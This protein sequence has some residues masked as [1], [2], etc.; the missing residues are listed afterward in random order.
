MFGLNQSLGW[1]SNPV[2]VMAQPPLIYPPFV[3]A[4]P[5]LYARLCLGPT[6]EAPLA[7]VTYRVSTHRDYVCALPQT[8]R[9]QHGLLLN[10]V[11]TPACARKW[12]ALLSQ[13]RTADDRGSSNERSQAQLTAKGDCQEEDEDERVCAICNAAM[14]RNMRLYVARNMHHNMRCEN[15]TM[16]PATSDGCSRMFVL[17]PL[18]C[19]PLLIRIC[20]GCATSTL[21]WSNISLPVRRANP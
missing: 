4:Q 1:D 8:S 6:I 18:A 5:L 13:A 3:K 15:M 10:T 2:A 16:Q 7:D 14:Q 19:L 11:G 17:L 9:P 20:T 21:Y 12:K